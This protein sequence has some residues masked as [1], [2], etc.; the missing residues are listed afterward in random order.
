MCIIRSIVHVYTVQPSHVLILCQFS[1]SV[2]RQQLESHVLVDC[3]VE[4]RREG[5]KTTGVDI[6]LL[7]DDQCGVGV[8]Y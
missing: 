8:S 2:E 4:I 1:E 5:G 6:D 7:S 3:S